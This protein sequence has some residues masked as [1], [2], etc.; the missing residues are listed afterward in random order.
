M[1]YTMSLKN[2]IDRIDHMS[3]TVGDRKMYNNDPM[4]SYHNIL[5]S[6]DESNTKKGNLQLI[7]SNEELPIAYSANHSVLIRLSR[8]SKLLTVLRD[9]ERKIREVA[10]TGMC[11]APMVKESEED[12]DWDPSFKLKTEY[13]ATHQNSTG[14]FEQGHV[15]TRC[16]F[17]VSRLNH[18][19]GT[20]HYALILKSALISNMP[21]SSSS[22]SSRQEGIERDNLA[23][24][25]EN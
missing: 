21:S 1:K 16:M 7:V 13:A 20:Y 23:M 18:Y 5:A 12:E 14:C 17:S 25:D 15:L 11:I 6:C 24:L 8:D 9:I 4:Y 2:D 3:F 22:S 10:P 19:Q